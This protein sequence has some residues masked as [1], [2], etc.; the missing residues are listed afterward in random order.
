M[1]I[2]GLFAIMA[3]M[4]MA[5]PATA[6]SKVVQ[7]KIVETSDVH[8]CFFP[9]DFTERKEKKGSLARVS[10]YVNGLRHKHGDNVILLENGDILQGQPICYYY[11]YINKTGN[12]VASDIVN[13]MRYDAQCFG[14]HDVEVG[15]EAYDKWISELK[16][17]VLGA[18]IIDTKTDKPYVQPYK[19]FNRD[20][21][22]V[23]VIG[24]LTPAIPSW[25]SEDLWNGMRF[26]GIKESMTKWVEHL[27]KTEQPE[28]I[29]ALLHNGW[30]NGIVT[31]QYVENE[32]KTVAEQVPGVDI[33]MF[34][35]DHR[36]RKEYI[37]N[38]DGR[39]VL[40]LD[41]S[42]NALKVAEATVTIE[43]N[44]KGKILKKI[45][46]GDLVD[47]SEEPVDERLM[48]AFQS[49]IDATNKYVD[50]ELGTLT[51]TIYTRDG[52]FGSSDFIDLIHNIQLKVVDAE[53]SFN[54]PLGYNN[55]IDKGTIR[56]SDMFKL[57]RFE[58]NLYVMK[59]T[60]KEIRNMLEMS[61]DQW[62]NT[63]TS[64]DDHIMLLS[65]ETNTDMQRMG[66][67]NLTF[68]FDSAAGIDYEVDVTK[69]DGQ[70]VRILQMSNGQPFNEDRMYR[71]A[72]NSYRGNGGGE[73][74]TLG[75]GITKE[76]LE[77]RI[78]YKSKKDLRQYIME[79]IQ[80]MGT[81]KPQP[82]NNWRFVPQKIAEPAIKR[83]K[84]LLFGKQQ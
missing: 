16:C 76:E 7:I 29:V 63:M 22:K 39:D 6:K 49:Q 77:D 78:I 34:G 4:L 2:K 24:M 37:K 12:N 46:T 45:I 58:N 51:K 27:Q 81:I 83:D 17:P 14:N 26:E 15:H 44:K 73:L 33:V 66:F 9:Y 41:P 1:K 69:P 82:N 84:E 28:V 13:Y 32:A 21:I 40:C 20:G 36:A 71:V 5:M 74:I 43:I 59:M 3:S 53:I 57:Y 60:G 80:R 56:V 54:A 67:K 31:D 19:I 42:N 79:E 25:L 52:F 50:T 70:K 18:N 55:K 47:V 35:H 38:V 48:A 23:A 64:P 10:T 75:A 72:M 61:Y 68:N 30:D 8:G 62:V 11:N 65:E